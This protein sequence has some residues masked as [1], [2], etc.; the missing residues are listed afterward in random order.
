M[1]LLSGSKPVWIDFCVC[2]LTSTESFL[3]YFPSG[4]LSESD[5]MTSFKK[6]SLYSSLTSWQVD[7]GIF[8]FFC[9]LRYLSTSPESLS[10]FSLFS[11]GTLSKI[12]PI[13]FRV[14]TTPSMSFVK[15]ISSIKHLRQKWSTATSGNCW[16]ILLTFAFILYIESIWLWTSLVSK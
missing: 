16:R 5:N 14:L 13:S 7:N 2:V 10:F 1:I 9:N 3:K 6:S 4:W 8:S 15:T 12:S 11:D